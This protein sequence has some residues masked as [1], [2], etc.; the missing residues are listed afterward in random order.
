[1][2]F[3]LKAPLSLVA[4]MLLIALVVG[5]LIGGKL[6]HDWNAS[7]SIP[8]G[9][10]TK[11]QQ[12]ADL[13]ARPFSWPLLPAGTTCPDGPKSPQGVYGS[14]PFHGVP[15]LTQGSSQTPW[16]SYFDLVGSTDSTATGLI[17]IRARDLS[18]GQS[19]VFV[20]PYATGPVVGTDELHGQ[21][22]QQRRELLLDMA[23][24]P[25]GPGAS[26]PNGGTYWSFTVGAA[27]AWP[28][29]VEWQVDGAG[30]TETF[31]FLS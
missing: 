12:V 9:G 8:A 14:G 24:R 31:S 20:G 21:S 6:V 23:H 18:T 25:S 15:A 2:V 7:H 5:A 28:S 30:F 3:R 16:G 11:A 19:M 10:L 26:A 17:L 1:M 29:C 13:E 4:V 22:V 27:K